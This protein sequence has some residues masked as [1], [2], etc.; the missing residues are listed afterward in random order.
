MKQALGM[1][2]TIGFATAMA[3]LDGAVKASAVTFLGFERVIG[4]GKMV[5]ITVK[6][7]GEVAAVKAAVDAGAAAARMVGGVFACHIL[8]RPHDSLEPLIMSEETKASLQLDNY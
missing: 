7:T 5:T 1:I 6:L 4:A 8:P 2:E 3:A